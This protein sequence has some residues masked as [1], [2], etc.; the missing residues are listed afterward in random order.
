MC[1]YA[2]MEVPS[3]LSV[4]SILYCY[5]LLLCSFARLDWCCFDSGLSPAIGP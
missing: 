1:N 2:C 4:R 3:D 5:I